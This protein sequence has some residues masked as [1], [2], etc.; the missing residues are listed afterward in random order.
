MVDSSLLD[1]SMSFD[2]FGY[3][4]D[5]RG[6]GFGS[7]TISNMEKVMIKTHIDSIQRAQ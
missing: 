4:V 6:K 3:R 7:V 2:I 1:F 5:G